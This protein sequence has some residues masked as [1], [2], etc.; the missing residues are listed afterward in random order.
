MAATAELAERLD[1]RLHTHLAEDPDEDDFCLER[2]G[3]RPV[4]QFAEVGWLNPRVR[5]KQAAPGGSCGLARRSRPG[6]R[7]AR[8][9]RTQP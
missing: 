4:E 1:V 6:A 8:A 2:F 3:R 7:R 5:P 9:A